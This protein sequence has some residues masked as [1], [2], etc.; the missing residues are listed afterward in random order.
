M[1]RSIVRRLRPGPRHRRPAHRCEGFDGLRQA[2]GMLGFLAAAPLAAIHA[3]VPVA[4][5]GLLAFVSLL[6]V[7]ATPFGAIPRRLRGAYEHLMGIDLQDHGRR[8]RP[9]PQL[10]LRKRRRRQ[11]REEEAQAALRQGPGRRRRAWRATSA[12]RPSNMRSS[13]TTEPTAPTAQARRQGRPAVAP[14]VRRPTQAEIAVEK[15][16]AA[17][18]LGTKGAGCRRR[19]TPPRPFRSSPRAWWPP[20]R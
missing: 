11:R 3:A 12:T 9:R 19:R 8:R 7:T 5:Y 20:V 15:I 16:K 17:Q 2:G 13:M 6:I 18:G 4:L 14:G 10:P 1:I